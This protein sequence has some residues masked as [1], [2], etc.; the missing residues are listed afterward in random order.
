M[1]REGEIMWVIR[2]AHDDQLFWSNSHGWVESPNEDYF[3]QEERKTLMLPFEG[4]WV[5]AVES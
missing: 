5:S 1:N 4:V 2:N 3:T